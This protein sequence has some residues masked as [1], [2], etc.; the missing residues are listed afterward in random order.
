MVCTPFWDGIVV[1]AALVLIVLAVV[2]CAGTTLTKSWR[3][4]DYRGQ[5]FKKL[6]VVGVSDW[7][8]LRRSFEEEFVKE[9]KAAGVDAV[10]SFVLLPETGQADEAQLTQAVKEA[11]ADGAL[12]THL[13]RVDV[14]T[15]VKQVYMPVEIGFYD[16]YAVAW[17]GS[18]KV[19]VSHTDTVVL[20][21]DLYSVQDSQLVWSATTQTVAATSI[22]KDLPGFAKLIIGEL[23]RQKLITGALA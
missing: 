11:G 19:P 7:P 18:Y 17:A 1:R 6:L 16:G 2:A 4:P 20:E 12:I 10:P 21:T 22:Q 9:L 8:E 23:R 3:S 15:E 13:I 5:P 14:Q